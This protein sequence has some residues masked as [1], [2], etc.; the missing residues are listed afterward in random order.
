M[1]SNYEEKT[2]ESYF[3]IELD[4]K[5]SCFF[6]LGQVQ[7]GVLGFDASAYT[8]SRKLWRRLGFPF[9]FSPPFHGI[10]LREIADEM[11]YYLRIIIEDI[12]KM[13]VNILFQYKK[14]EYITSSLGAEWPP[15]QQS[16][17]RYDIYQHQQDLLNHIDNALGNLV[18]TVYASPAIKDIDDL[19]TKKINNQ[20]IDYSNFKK[21]RDLNG[22]ER[23]TYIEA[24]TYSIAFSEPER[25][26]NLNLINE[27]EQLGNDKLNSNENNLQ[28]ILRFQQQ[29][30]L[31]MN[32]NL[33]YG[34]SFRK[35]DELLYEL[36]KYELLYS[37]L[38]M[39]NFRQL[40]GNQWLIKL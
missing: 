17:Y 19:V 23:N 24:G 10:N 13:K 31:I 12:P 21:A 28:F 40:T 6:P 25:I 29:I 30:T 34:E 20:I 16:Y 7:E 36:R 37:F 1:R 33:Y 9:W 4:R 8:N 27:L 15:W 26:A 22:H 2:F 5:S 3:N 18:F 14:P 32:Q 38:V 39:H 35:L 11:E